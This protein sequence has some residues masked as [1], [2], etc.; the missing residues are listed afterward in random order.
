METAIVSHPSNTQVNIK[1][2]GG[3]DSKLFTYDH[4]FEESASQR[5]LFECFRPMARDF[6]EGFNVTIIAYGQTGS[7]KTYTMGSM[8]SSMQSPESRGLIPRFLDELFERCGKL[9]QG[10]TVEVDTSFLEIYGEDIYDL[11]EPSDQSFSS[12]RAPLPIR[13]EPNGTVSVAGLTQLPVSD[14]AEVK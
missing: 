4:V 6:M 8:D 1:R 13:E 5:D 14:C 10:H 7:G 12:K 3:N 11:L 9:N 2:H